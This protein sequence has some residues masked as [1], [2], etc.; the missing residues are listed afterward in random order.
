VGHL[1]GGEGLVV[2]LEFPGLG[3]DRVVDV[4][5]VADHA[6]GV[7]EVLEPSDEEVEGEVGEGVA[8][9]GG[10]VWRDAA[11]VHRHL[12]P[13]LEGHDLAADGVVEPHGAPGLLDLAHGA[14]P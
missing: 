5:D 11:H 9:V 10:V 14:A 8:E 7:A 3:E 13:G 1:D 6:H 4:G 12:G 2:D